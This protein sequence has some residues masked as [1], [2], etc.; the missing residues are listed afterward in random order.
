MKSSKK[1]KDVKKLM[2]R[3]ATV[4][5]LMAM[6]MIIEK[7]VT[8]SVVTKVYIWLFVLCLVVALVGLFVLL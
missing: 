1:M 8:N 4:K 7:E 6:G 3:Q 2:E 5:D